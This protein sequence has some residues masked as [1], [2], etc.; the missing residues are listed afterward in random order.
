MKDIKG[1]DTIDR[2]LLGLLTENAERS[3]AELGKLVGLSAPAVHERVKR[4]KASGRI[5][6]VVAA[7]EPVE[8][9]KGFL[10]FIHVD[11]TGWG[12][13]KELMALAELPEVEEIHSVTGDTCMLLK[14]RMETSQAMEALLARLYAMPSV[15][16]TKSYMVLST[17]LERPVQ[18]GITE[19]LVAP[20]VV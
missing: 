4:H 19:G 2:K 18:A 10:S 12:K 13:T 15:T 6:S 20:E 8:T 1:L 9:G 14:V 16:A 5:K 3:Y 11:T 17:Y 7:L